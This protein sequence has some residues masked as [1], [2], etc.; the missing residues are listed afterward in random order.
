MLQHIQSDRRS[1]AS[2]ELFL[3]LLIYLNNVTKRQ[4]LTSH[5]TTLCHATWRSYNN[6]RLL[7]RHFTLCIR[8]H[9][10][11]LT[12]SRQQST[13]SNRRLEM[14]KSKRISSG[15]DEPD[16]LVAFLLWFGC[17]DA[18]VSNSWQV[19]RITD[20]LTYLKGGESALLTATQ[21]DN[22]NIS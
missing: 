9:S 11:R 20:L 6:H 16:A 1:G 2:N 14:T 19:S 17:G 22:Q 8:T 3:N 5:S 4:Q 7:W 10:N 13:E 18:N 12:L 21:I 15:N